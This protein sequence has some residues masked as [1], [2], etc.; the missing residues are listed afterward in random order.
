MMSGEDLAVNVKQRFPDVTR[1]QRAAAELIKRIRKLRW[2]GLEDEARRV[3]RSSLRLCST[4][5][6][7]VESAPRR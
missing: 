2:M 1:E 6:F 5:E 3:V 7:V 4:D